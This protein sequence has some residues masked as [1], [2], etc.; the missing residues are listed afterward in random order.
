MSFS[1]S[2]PC[3]LELTN[4]GHALIDW[5]DYTKVCGRSW[6]RYMVG[7]KTKNPYVAATTHTKADGKRKHIM[8]YLHRVI[9]DAPI[10]RDVD[11]INRDTLDNRR[12]NLRIASRGEN[13]SNSPRPLGGSGY[14]GVTKTPEGNFQARVGRNGYV[15]RFDVAE[16]AARAYDAEAHKRYGEFATLNFPHE[17]TSA[18]QTADNK[19]KD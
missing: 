4:G 13:L 8:L 14:R 19:V 1:Q 12:A 3:M 18:A 2:F 17:R 5:S 7:K 11:H 6:R 10:G 9:M 16:E 15:G